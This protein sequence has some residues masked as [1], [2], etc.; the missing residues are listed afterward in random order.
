[1]RALARAGVEPALTN[2][3]SWTDGGRLATGWL[4]VECALGGRLEAISIF[5]RGGSTLL[6]SVRTHNLDLAIFHQSL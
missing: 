2:K 5:D 1:L 3:K 4:E 6:A